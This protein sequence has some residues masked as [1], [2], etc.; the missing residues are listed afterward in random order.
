[1]W[2]ESSEEEK[3]PY[4][5]E[6]EN[7]KKNNTQATIEFKKKLELWEAKA[8]VFTK[9]WRE[10]HLCEPGEEE[11]AAIKLAEAEVAHAKRTRKLN[12]F[13]SEED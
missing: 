9:E 3:R 8:E 2:R 7:N 6:T 4:L 5:A 13:L 1:M 10:K 12:G 11:T